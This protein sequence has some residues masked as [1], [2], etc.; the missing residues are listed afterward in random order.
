MIK[1]MTLE[2]TLSEKNQMQKSICHVILFVQNAHKDGT[3]FLVAKDWEVGTGL[4]RHDGDV[5]ANAVVVVI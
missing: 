1:H 4:L 3:R 2:N 5:Q